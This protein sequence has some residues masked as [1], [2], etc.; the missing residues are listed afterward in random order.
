MATKN[1]NLTVALT[2]NQT[3]IESGQG[4]TPKAGLTWVAV[5]LRPYFQGKGDFFFFVDDQQYIQIASEDVATYGTPWVGAIQIKQPV[6]FHFK[7]SDRSA[8][9][10]AVG[11][12]FTVEESASTS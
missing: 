12:D 9:N 11:V 7:F 6:I 4:L 5:E 8:A 1:F 2:S 3:L 10:N